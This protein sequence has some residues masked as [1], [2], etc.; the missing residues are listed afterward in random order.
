MPLI[1][2]L[3]DRVGVHVEMGA[4]SAHRVA[5]QLH[6]EPSADGTTEYTSTLHH[7]TAPTRHCSRALHPEPEQISWTELA[8]W[9]L[10][11]WAKVSLCECSL[12]PLT[13]SADHAFANW[14]LG[15]REA[16]RHGIGTYRPRLIKVRQYQLLGASLPA[17]PDARS[18]QLYAATQEQLAAAAAEECGLGAVGD[19]AEKRRQHDTQ[20]LRT[21]RQWVL[22]STEEPAPVIIGWEPQHRTLY[23]HPGVLAWPTHAPDVAETGPWTALR[24]ALEPWRA[25]HAWVRHF[26]DVLSSEELLLW[27]PHLDPAECLTLRDGSQLMRV[28]LIDLASLQVLPAQV[29]APDL[30]WSA[31]DVKLAADLAGP[32]ASTQ[33]VTDYLRALQAANQ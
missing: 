26:P 29:A 20:V 4:M 24:A 14:V 31:H 16:V 33:R 12:D 3:R 10:V 22:A 19:T 6:H 11:D 27:L 28:P 9:S 25:L 30:G 21:V 23:G 15:A 17:R 18:Q 5:Y 1:G 8:H 32:D 13:T 7:H 2:R